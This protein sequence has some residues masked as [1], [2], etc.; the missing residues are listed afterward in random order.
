MNFEFLLPTKVVMRKGIR[1][2]TGEYLVTEA[3][4]L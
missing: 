4:W 1:H 2:E 3:S